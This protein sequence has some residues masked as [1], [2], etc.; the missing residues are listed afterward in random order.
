MTLEVGSLAPELNL[1]DQHGVD[2]SLSAL[3]GQKSL[4][5]VFYPFAFS[6]VCNGELTSFRDHLQMFETDQTTIA[7]VSCDPMFSLRAYDDRDALFFPLLSDFWPHGSVSRNYG[8]F[9]EALGCS[10]RS[11]YVINAEGVVTWVVHSQMGI[12]RDLEE[13][14]KELA[15]AV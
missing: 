5:L 1:P 3:R 9:D 15:R 14:A 8:V 7:A 12:A 13:Q 4:L 11:S 2:F 10:T 6:G